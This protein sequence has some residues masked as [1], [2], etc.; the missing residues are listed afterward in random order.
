M[1]LLHTSDWHLGH[2][3]HDWARDEE[4]AAFFVWLQ[5]TIREQRVDALIVAGDIFD[6][7][8]P[9]AQALRSW[10]ELLAQLRMQSPELEIVV[11]GGNH[12]SPARLDAANPL[13]SALRI[14]VVGGMPHRPV[15]GVFSI[16]PH[17]LERLVVPLRRQGEIAAWVA[18]VPFL[19]PVDL[20]HLQAEDP[21]IEGVRRVYD[22]VISFARA[23]RDP[24]HAI[25]ATGHL[26][27]TGTSLSESSERKILGGNLHALPADIFPEDVAYAAL[28]HLH[29]PQMV[30]KRQNVR[31]S[32]SPIPLDA[33]EAEYPH[34][35]QIVD[36]EGPETREILSL[37]TP[38]SVEIWRVPSGGSLPVEDLLLA[39]RALDDR[40]IAE[41]P[42][43]HPFLEVVAR[44]TKPEPSL[45]RKVEEALEGKKVRL[46]KI[47]R[48]LT[49]TS[50]PLAET[51]T[52]R[53]LR[54][55]RPEDVFVERYRRDHEGAGPPEELLAAFREL[56][57]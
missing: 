43:R 12:D 48:E 14:H 19:R 34:Q 50:L 46:V 42:S 28:G 23:R 51:T 5:H 22:E 13:L 2:T 6:T 26:Y 44:L 37:K 16:A 29:R 15:G 31:Y 25:V 30:A 56:L 32:G 33:S 24:S 4:H 11:I 52:S 54:D 27:M 3:L 1:R 7:A 38:R 20:P 40:A 36:L 21:L 49:G 39:L 35:V 10:Y 17:T 45:H 47:T 8:N 53:T 57:E 55:L 9:S 41:S 18:A